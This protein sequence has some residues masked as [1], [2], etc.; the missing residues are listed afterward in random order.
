ML[1]PKPLPLGEENPLKILLIEIRVDEYQDHDP[2]P[3]KPLQDQDTNP[4]LT[5]EIIIIITVSPRS[6]FLHHDCSLRSPLRLSLHLHRDH[7]FQEQ[8]HDCDGS[9]LHL[10]VS[11]DKVCH[12]E[13]LPSSLGWDC[14]HPRHCRHCSLLCRDCNSWDCDYLCHCHHCSFSLCRDCNIHP[15]TYR[16][17]LQ[18]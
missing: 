17:L 12:Y 4:L 6:S 1:G 15:K 5:V 16:L 9:W 11:R 8:D 2:W 7:N 3:I 13:I 18:L 10:N 14:D